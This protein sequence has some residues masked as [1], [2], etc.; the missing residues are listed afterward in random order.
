MVLCLH[1][2]PHPPLPA[3]G[4]RLSS[5][6]KIQ[7]SLLFILPNPLLALQTD[8]VVAVPVESR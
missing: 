6:I 4:P 2:P 3:A 1:D 7:T 5:G 8:T